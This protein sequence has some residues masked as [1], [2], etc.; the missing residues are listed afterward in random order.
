MTMMLAIAILGGG[1]CLA[2]YAIIASVLPNIDRIG[3]AL[4]GRPLHPL[5]AVPPMATARRTAIRRP[6]TGVAAARPPLCAA[7]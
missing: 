6:A 7:A 2:A 3:A 1:F 5:P 4:A